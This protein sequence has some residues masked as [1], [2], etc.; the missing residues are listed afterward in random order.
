MDIDASG[1]IDI[2]A[3]DRIDIVTSDVV[4]VGSTASNA[5]LYSNGITQISAT[6][7]VIINGQGG[8][9]GISTASGILNIWSTGGEI[10]INSGNLVVANG[11][12]SCA[13][14]AYVSGTLKVNNG[15]TLLVES[16][17]AFNF[18]GYACQWENVGGKY[19]ITRAP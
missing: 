14:N 9:N 12:L 19:Y 3:G 17:A 1:G 2:L 6:G 7:S 4:A 18:L 16:G 8:A 13:N 15:G 10:N 11:Y 5:S